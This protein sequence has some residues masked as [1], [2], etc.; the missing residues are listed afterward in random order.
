MEAERQSIKIIFIF[1]FVKAIIYFNRYLALTYF[2]YTPI[3]CLLIY[4]TLF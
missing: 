1:I 3:L 4:R 2:N